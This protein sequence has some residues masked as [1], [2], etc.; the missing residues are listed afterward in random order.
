MN[1]ISVGRLDDEGYSGNFRNGTWKFSKQNLIVAHA[2]KENTLYVMHARLSRNEANLAA[3]IAGD[4]WHKRLC[5]MSQM[6][7]HMLAEK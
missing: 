4:L 2:R 3:D 6:G 5:H 7:M 1:L